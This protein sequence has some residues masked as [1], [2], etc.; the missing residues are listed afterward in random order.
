VIPESKSLIAPW[1]ERVRYGVKKNGY[2]GGISP[3]EMIIPI[4]VLNATDDFP[5]GWVEAA[6]DLPVWWDVA[7][8]SV[9]ADERQIET[10]KPQKPKDKPAGMLFDLDQEPTQQPSA[11]TTPTVDRGVPEWVA[12]LLSSPVFEEQKRLG[13]RA[14][15]ANDVLTRLLVAIDERGGK[16]TS[17]ALARAI[18]FSPLRLR[19]LL[20]IA[21]RLLNVDGFSVL[22]RDE[23]SDTVELDRNLLC[24]QFDLV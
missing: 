2:H 14:V 11:A 15:P 7:T 16:I 10:L 5:A 8:P 17:P 9:G 18:Q 3:Q 21:Q 4:A 22:T 24:R 19:G 23:A 12:A 13:G 20:A 6:V 1:T